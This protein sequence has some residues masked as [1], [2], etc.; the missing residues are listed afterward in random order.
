MRSAVLTSCVQ[1][2]YVASS[3]YLEHNADRLSTPAARGLARKLAERTDYRLP[4]GYYDD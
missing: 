3:D 2:S 1:A 4:Q